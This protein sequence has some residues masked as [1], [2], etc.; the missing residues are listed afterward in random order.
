MLEYWSKSL[1]SEQSLL[2]IQKYFESNNN[3]G[4]H[5]KTLKNF[6]DN[7]LKWGSIGQQGLL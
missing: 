4:T 6:K 3:R 2:E 1:V 5:M 7:T